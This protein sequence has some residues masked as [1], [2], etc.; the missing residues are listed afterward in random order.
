MKEHLFEVSG[1]KFEIKLGQTVQD[2]LIVQAFN[3]STG[4]PVGFRYSVSF[5]TNVDMNNYAGISGIQSLIE[6][7]K[8]DVKNK[9]WEE[10]AEAMKNVPQQLMTTSETDWI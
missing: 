10:V 5:D 7:A 1:E 2:E 9:R 4:K 6:I 8:D 3:V